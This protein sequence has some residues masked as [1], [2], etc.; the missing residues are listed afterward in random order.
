MSVEDEGDGQGNGGGND[1]D[2]SNPLKEAP[3]KV[4]KRKPP[5]H[6]RFQRGN[7]GNRKGRL[8][9]PEIDVAEA[10]NSVGAE[11][12]SVKLNG[13]PK[14]M[15]RLEVTVALQ[16]QAALKGNTRAARALL[17]RAVKHGFVKEK[18]FKSNIEFYEPNGEFGEILRVY[19]RLS[20][21]HVDRRP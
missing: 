21:L 17:E 10:M 7:V 14:M 20:A 9:A 19:P 13:R 3:Y 6:T 2:D 11:R 15:S 1:D 8:K 16:I 4:G 5:L 18:L 12:R